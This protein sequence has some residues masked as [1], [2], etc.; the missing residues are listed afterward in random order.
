MT[1]IVAGAT[2]LVGSA[3]VKAFQAAGQE[4]VGINRN[5]VE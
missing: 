3:I 5:V 1:V 4:V 2:G